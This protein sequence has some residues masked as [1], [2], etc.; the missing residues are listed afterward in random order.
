MHPVNIIPNPVIPNPYAK[1]GSIG[2]HHCADQEVPTKNSDDNN[3]VPEDSLPRDMVGVT[4]QAKRRPTIHKRGSDITLDTH[5]RRHDGRDS[6][7]GSFINDESV[8]VDSPA[9][10]L[11]LKIQVAELQTELQAQQVRVS[12]YQALLSQVHGEYM[13]IQK[14]N[15]EIK[16]SYKL[17][18]KGSDCLKD[19]LDLV[20]RE[21]T[22]LKK[23]MKTMFSANRNSECMSIGSDELNDS[24][25]SG[26]VSSAGSKL[27]SG[28][29]PVAGDPNETHGDS[30]NIGLHK[31]NEKSNPKEKSNDVLLLGDSTSGVLDVEFQ[32]NR[33]GAVR[34]SLS[35]ATLRAE[36]DIDRNLSKSV[37]YN[38]DA[39]AK[40]YLPKTVLR[41]AASGR[42]DSNSTAIVNN[43]S[44]QK[45]DRSD[46]DASFWKTHRIAAN[47][48]PSE[49]EHEKDDDI[50][51]DEDD[52]S[53]SLNDDD[54]NELEFKLREINQS[55]G[56]GGGEFVPAQIK[57][58]GTFSSFVRNLSANLST[59]I[60]ALS[61]SK[62]SADAGGV[63]DATIE[64][65]GKNCISEIVES[66]QE[67]TQKR[68]T[69]LSGGEEMKLLREFGEASVT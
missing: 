62:T 33:A 36:L 68:F 8:A 12:K 61:N 1:N 35:A 4:I 52:D 17:L 45:R 15:K 40:S 53:F 21:N 65:L 44:N 7:N 64:E 51:V 26:G 27:S 20:K 38:E 39:A 55:S 11:A 31:H 42:Q 59:S 22:E 37:L 50:D 23:V 63:L 57:P 54:A 25:R 24:L 43:R 5:L 10:M 18:M 3:G 46:S 67:S 6:L 49:D 29:K 28:H 2:P 14:E 69:K 30:D 60:N 32:T 66:V 56:G 13:A 19:Q 9:D 47:I 48:P 34:K 16:Q 58:A 41:K